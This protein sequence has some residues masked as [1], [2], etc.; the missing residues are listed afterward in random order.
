MGYIPSDES[1]ALNAQVVGDSYICR[2]DGREQHVRRAAASGD[3]LVAMN[4]NRD[5]LLYWR[6]HEPTAPAATV[7]IG[8]LTS[9]SIQDFAIVTGTVTGPDTAA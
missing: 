8:R 9:R 2:Y 3:W 1:T 5:R 6:P 7:N 4:D